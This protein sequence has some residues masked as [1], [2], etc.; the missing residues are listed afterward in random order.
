LLPVPGLRFMR[1]A[2]RGGLATVA[3]EIALG[4][5]LGVML[6]EEAI[7][8]R[9]STRSVCAMLGYDPLFL[10]CEGRVVAVLAAEDAET[11]LAAWRRLPN[12]A[13]AAMIGQMQ[14]VAGKVS[15]R[16]CIGGQR[17]LP[18]LEDDA[19]PRIC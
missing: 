8:V 7:P 18:E 1:D 2:T 16:T 4:A 11:A 5:K 3:H 17:I 10:A 19:L 13:Q 12:G 14:A 15:L 6:E 9:E